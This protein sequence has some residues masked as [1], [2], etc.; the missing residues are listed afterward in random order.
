[1]TDNN[2]SKITELIEEENDPKTRALLIVLNSIN[3]S[4][5]ANTQTVQDTDEQLKR[6]SVEF[7][8]R[9]LNEDA[10]VNKGKGA[11]W[12]LSVVFVFAQSFV[13]YAITSVSG[14]LKLL[15]QL[16][17]ALEHRITVIEEKK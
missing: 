2:K 17:A 13:F 8:K 11:W 7:N 4:L 16:D 5:I 1:M 15:H 10:M 3:E 6:L 12:A 9:A 14:E